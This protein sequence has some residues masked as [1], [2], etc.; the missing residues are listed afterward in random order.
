MD[1]AMKSRNTE[2]H[3]L[4][5]PFLLGE[6]TNREVFDDVDDD[7]RPPTR[8]QTPTST[9]GND[10]DLNE[11]EDQ[12]PMDDPVGEDDDDEIGSTIHVQGPGS[13]SEASQTENHSEQNE[14]SQSD[15]KE[16]IEPS[17]ASSR[18]RRNIPR[19]DYKSLHKRGVLYITKDDLKG[20]PPPIEPES[21]EEA[22]NGPYRI[23]WGGAMGSEISSQKE[24]KAYHLKKLLKNRRAL[25]GKW[26]FKV[27][28]EQDGSI[29]F[30]ARYVAQGFRQ[31]KGTDYNETYAS[32]IRAETSKLLTGLAAKF[33]WIIEHIDI[34]T[35]FLNSHLDRELY[36][37]Q[38]KGYREGD[39]DD[40]WLIDRGLYGLK[41]NALLWFDDCKE[42]VTT[43]CGLTQSMHD[44]ALFYCTKRQL[45]MTIWVD[46]ITIYC[47][48]RAV[49]EEFK[50]KLRTVYK[51]KELGTQIQYLGMEVTH[52]KDGS[53]LLT[54]QKYIETI[55]D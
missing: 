28:Y 34:M 14:P 37:K 42:F 55:L 18:P 21:Y 17:A 13:P 39:P 45:Y 43:K 25:G 30:K 52:Y 24:R 35:A 27:K 3:W 48:D 29:R 12:P 51:T 2:P 11:N 53:I 10:S 8:P 40:I 44:D 5:L 47:P 7:E 49:V 4:E 23:E 6:T 50:A 15:N 54:Q 9:H 41:Q 31:R 46:D 1:T 20:R 38:P 26:V 36:V 33:S 16:S 22:I 19:R 32:V